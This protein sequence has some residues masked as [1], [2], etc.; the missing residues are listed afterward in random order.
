MNN[1][2][3]YAENEVSYYL[4]VKY[5]LGNDLQPLKSLRYFP[6]VMMPNEIRIL[7]RIIYIPIDRL[8]KIA[9]GE[10]QNEKERQRQM[11]PRIQI[12]RSDNI[13]CRCFS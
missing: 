2:R 11:E 4:C 13:D 3:S 8:I 9:E 10:R 12:S 5:D 6:F 7:I 1:V